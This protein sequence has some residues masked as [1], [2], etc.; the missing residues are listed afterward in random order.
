MATVEPY[1]LN[2]SAENNMLLVSVG[3][4][5]PSIYE[6]IQ[7]SD[8]H[9]LFQASSLRLHSCLLL[10]M[11]KTLPCLRQVFGWRSLDR[12]VGDLVEKKGPVPKIFTYLR[13]NAELTQGLDG[14]DLV[15]SEHVQQMDSVDHIS[16]FSRWKVIAGRK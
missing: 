12:E 14:W 13:Y 4:G 15:A 2:W 16:G 5:T 6:D 10:R 7:P 3:T 1:N 9:K 11:S 8:M